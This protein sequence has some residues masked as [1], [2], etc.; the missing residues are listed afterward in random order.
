MQ[1]RLIGTA[2][3]DPPGFQYEQNEFAS[4]LQKVAP[5]LWQRASQAFRGAGLMAVID[6]LAEPSGGNGATAAKPAPFEQEISAL[7]SMV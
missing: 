1:V 3:H 5:W 6:Q 4:K 7:G 2:L